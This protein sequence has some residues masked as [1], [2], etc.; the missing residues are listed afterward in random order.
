M[1]QLVLTQALTKAEEQTRPTLTS[2]LTGWGRRR[3][4]AHLARRRYLKTVRTLSALDS[5]TLHDIGLERSEITSYAA[6]GGEDRHPARRHVP[7]YMSS[8]Y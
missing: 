4:Q 5:R 3:L 2:R 7:L 6:R 8:M 1:M